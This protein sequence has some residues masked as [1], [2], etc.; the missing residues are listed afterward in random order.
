MHFS[1]PSRSADNLPGS[2]SFR[3]KS[4]S[5]GSSRGLLGSLFS[6]LVSSSMSST[7]FEKRR[8]VSQRARRSILTIAVAVVVGIVLLIV[9]VVSGRLAGGSG[10]R[11]NGPSVV[12]VLGLDNTKYK[13]DYLGKVVENRKEYADAHGYGLYVRYNS[14]FK[15]LLGSSGPEWAKMPLMRAALEE[16]PGA[17]YFWYLDQN[18]IIMN[19]NLRLEDHVTDVKRLN[20]LILRD[21]PVVPPDGVIRTYRH[22]PVERMKFIVSQDHEGFQTGSFV[23][24]NGEYAKYV[25]DSWFDQLYRE[26]N[27]PKADRGALEHMAQWHPTILSKI[28]LVPQRILNSYPN[29]VGESKYEDGD[30]VASLYGCDSPERSCVREFERLWDDRGRAVM[31]RT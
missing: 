11:A 9:Y 4:R 8:Y 25:L 23:L 5:H 14:D 1:I 15:A 29:G 18:A 12:L 19:P 7:E 3:A 24:Q 2:P 27:F 20:S 16:N 10:K 21:V 6:P 28:A 22:V 31:R 30:F 17:T 13:D 26:Y